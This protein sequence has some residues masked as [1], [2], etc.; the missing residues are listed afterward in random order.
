MSNI[1]FPQ[2]V[3]DYVAKAMCRV[4]LGKQD[5]D[6]YV[7]PGDVEP[8]WYDYHGQA[9]AALESLALLVSMP[10]INILISTSF[11][12]DMVKVDSTTVW[13]HLVL[14]RESVVVEDDVHAVYDA[15]DVIFAE[16]E[17]YAEEHF[18]YIPKKEPA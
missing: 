16:A 13:G 10:K 1:V 18:G 8:A 12:D 17:K 7:R 11:V 14:R 6:N 15:R 3:I 2:A 5:I 9:R 4:E